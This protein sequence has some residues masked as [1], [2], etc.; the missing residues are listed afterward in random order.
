MSSPAPVAPS[1]ATLNRAL[2]LRYGCAV[3][4]IAAATWIRVL[5]DP[6]LGSE[7]PFPAMLFAILLTVWFGG[8]GPAL[9]AL[10]LAVFCADFFVVRPLPIPR[11]C[12][13]A[14]ASSCAM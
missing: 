14:L 5:L 2:L 3:M 9:L 1:N 11:V 10:V 8:F 7:S 13:K 4:T 6:T 12:W